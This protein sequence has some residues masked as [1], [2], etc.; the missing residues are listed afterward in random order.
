MFKNRSAAPDEVVHMRHRDY[1]SRFAEVMARQLTDHRQIGNW[2]SY[3]P[4]KIQI[5]TEL[6]ACLAKLKKAIDSDQGVRE[7]AADLA[8][9]CAKA[10][11]MFGK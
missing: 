2:D 11:E 3:K 4:G 8:N 10:A 6:D 9:F 5:I 1:T 7:K